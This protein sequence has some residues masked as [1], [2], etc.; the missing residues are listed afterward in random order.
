MDIKELFFGKMIL[1]KNDLVQ[2]HLY[3]KGNWEKFHD[4]YID[5]Y[6]NKQSIVLDIGA[7]VGTFSL[8]VS[9][10]C[11]VVYCFEPFIINYVQLINN[12]NINKYENII[13]FNFAISNKLDITK[14]NK[15]N[16]QQINKT[17]N[18]L[19]RRN[20]K[21]LFI[22]IP[23]IKPTTKT[24]TNTRSISDTNINYNF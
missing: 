1:N 22:N 23:K 21:S 7:H 10:K 13:P 12:I 14:V 3:L 11:K 8:K 5:K 20:L 9:K 4:E 17:T 6:I 19:K 24:Y 16:Q 18:L 2:N 15:T